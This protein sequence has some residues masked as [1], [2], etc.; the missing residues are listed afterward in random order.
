MTITA[1]D[2]TFSKR[3]ISARLASW[4]ADGRSE[5]STTNEPVAAS[6][7]QLKQTTGRTSCS[8]VLLPRQRSATDADVGRLLGEGKRSLTICKRVAHLT[9][10]FLK[11]DAV[12]ITWYTI[13]QPGDRVMAR[14]LTTEE[15]A[16]RRGWS[17]DSR[18]SPSPL[19]SALSTPCIVMHV[20]SPFE[21]AA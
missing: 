19:M 11:D 20:Y 4:R 2:S 8:V 5:L 3:R 12:Y 10:V 6:K 16:E 13:G 1:G 17:S 18:T 21:Q 9:V 14:N 7:V 15:K